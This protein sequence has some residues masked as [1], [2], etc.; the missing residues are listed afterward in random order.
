MKWLAALHSRQLFWMSFF[1]LKGITSLTD[2]NVGL[3]PRP[4]SIPRNNV[5]IWLCVC[6]IKRV[7]VLTLPKRVSQVPPA[8]ICKVKNVWN[9]F[10]CAPN[11]WAEKERRGEGECLTLP[12]KPFKKQWPYSF[13][14]VVCISKAKDTKSKGATCKICTLC[15]NS[16]ALG[17]PS[18]R[19]V[20]QFMG[21]PMVF[22]DP[23]WAIAINPNKCVL[24]AKRINSIFQLQAGWYFFLLQKGVD[25]WWLGFFCIWAPEPK[26]KWN[27]A[28]EQPKN[29]NFPL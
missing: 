6:N 13:L 11:K 19:K 3:Y 18:L 5:L 14:P 12:L 16:L 22:D 10:N 9:R 7:E 21:C 23:L 27:T 20:I 24:H 26:W 1:S 2:E 17:P 8:K 4:R 25:C 28:K 29:N 15:L